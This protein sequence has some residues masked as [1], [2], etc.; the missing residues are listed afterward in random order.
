MNLR[1]YSFLFLWTLFPTQISTAQPSGK[2]GTISRVKSNGKTGVAGLLRVHPVNPRY[3]SDPSGAIVYLTGSHTWPSVLDMTGPSGRQQ[4]DDNSF[5][6]FISGHG[7]N[8]TRLWAFENDGFV[9]SEVTP[10]IY[11]HS[12]TGLPHDK[13]RG[14]DLSRFN[15]DY[16]ERLK[17]RVSAANDRG[18]YV[19]V[20]LFGHAGNLGGETFFKKENNINGIDGDPDGDGIAIETRTLQIPSVTA[21]QEAYVK[22]VIETLNSF[23]NVLFEIA[24]ESGPVTT[25]WQYHMIRFIKLQETT[26]AKKH[27]V[28]MSSDGGSVMGDDTERLFKSEAEWIGP[29]WNTE[30]S[31]TYMT[32]PPA[33]TGEKVILIDSDHLWGIGGDSQWVWKSF[34][35]GLHPNYMDP[36]VEYDSGATWGCTQ[37]QFD[38]ARRAMGLT[39]KVA[40]QINLVSMIPHNELSSTTYCLADPGKEYLVYFPDG[41]K[42]TIDLSHADRKLKVQWLKPTDG[43]LINGGVIA[44]GKQ[45]QVEVP[46]G[47]DAILYLTKKTQLS[48]GRTK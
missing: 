7:H 14:Y 10:S 37:K 27:L 36:Y 44:G 13:K 8:F 34:L 6:D 39:L 4:P 22:K 32:D 26:M 12:G 45:R 11:K 41:G 42:G 1:I 25:S 16:F 43:G 24:T 29:G 48:P 33:A 9:F 46:F 18:I 19:A 23:D 17:A 20:V 31:S 3:F 47:G 28:G 40:N 2:P 35:R 5:L 15:E 21:L 38:G 30:T